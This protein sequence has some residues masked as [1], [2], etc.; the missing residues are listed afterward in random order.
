MSWTVEKLAKVAKIDRNQ[1]DAASISAGTRYLGLEHIESGGRILDAPI[2]ERGQLKS[3][4]FRFTDEH[5]LYGKLR[6]YL[7]KISLPDFEGI[8]STDILP[9]LPGPKLDRKYLA[10]FLRQPVMIN[11]ANLRTTGANLPRLSPKALADF[12]VPFPSIEDQRKIVTILQKADSVRTKG[13]QILLLTNE[14]LKSAFLDTFGDP[15]N[16]P[17]GWKLGVIGDCLDGVVAGWSARG[18][19]RPADS[20]EMGVLKISA[21]TSGEYLPSENKVVSSVPSEKKLIVPQ[22]GDLLFSRANTRE[23]VAATCIVVGGPQ[24]VFLPDKLWRLDINQ[25]VAVTAYLKFAL[26]HSEFRRL[27]CARATGTS[28]SM[29]NISKKKL[30]DH[31]IPIPPI[32]LQNEFSTLWQSVRSVTTQLA[33]KNKAARE[34]FS[35]LSQSA[36]RGKL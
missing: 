24:N 33:Q 6:P 14:L 22:S 11:Q 35:S 17:L 4:K 1:V 15:V 16:N 19:A 27:L 30:I 36:F 25:D 3:S 28:G 8:C 2:V 7:A 34:L 29:L 26:A 5:V 9:V 13:E 31:P 12:D 18:D 21:V 23:L 20:T 10:Y 32:E